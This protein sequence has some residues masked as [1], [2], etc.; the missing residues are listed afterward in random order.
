M[1]ARL[2]LYTL[3]VQV[4]IERKSSTDP[5]GREHEGRVVVGVLSLWALYILSLLLLHVQVPSWVLVLHVRPCLDER[6][7][8]KNTVSEF[9]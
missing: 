6:I 5:S 4:T 9:M 7:E 1:E 3:G 2:P 8:E